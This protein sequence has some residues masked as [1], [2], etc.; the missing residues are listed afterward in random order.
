MV[1]PDWGVTPATD[2]SNPGV[3]T[4]EHRNLWNRNLL[5][6][7]HWISYLSLLFSVLSLLV[8]SGLRFSFARTLTSTTDQKSTKGNFSCWHHFLTS[9]SLTLSREKEQTLSHEDGLKSH[10]FIFSHIW[11]YLN[12]RQKMPITAVIKS[13]VCEIMTLLRAR[14]FWTGSAPALRASLVGCFPPRG[15]T[16][17]P[18]QFV[19][20]VTCH[21]LLQKRKRRKGCGGR[22]PLFEILS[23][24][25]FVKLKTSKLY[26]KH[27]HA[28][29]PRASTR[30]HAKFRRR[31]CI[32]KA[33][34]AWS[35]L[36]QWCP[37]H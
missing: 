8:S 2:Y 22:H 17:T 19:I 12:L 24:T 13:V 9:L 4:R 36:S 29:S 15:C 5:S 28:R 35:L 27:T 1:K 14:H 21:W 7:K 11:L 6:P 25:I 32:L 26:Y 31:L 37:I 23:L 3:C 30:T 34:V 20:R 10:S 16:W 18:A 33:L